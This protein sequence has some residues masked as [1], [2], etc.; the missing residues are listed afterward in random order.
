MVLIWMIWEK[1]SDVATKVEVA[2]DWWVVGVQLI[3][4]CKLMR[5]KAGLA[6][7]HGSR[8]PAVHFV[9]WSG[10]VRHVETST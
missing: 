2:D 3:C 9:P 7:G 4:D 1:E 10:R 6:L 5:K 8:I